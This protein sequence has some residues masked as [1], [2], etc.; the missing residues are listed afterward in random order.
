MTIAA[1]AYYSNNGGNQAIFSKAG[2][3]ECSINSS[4]EL[5]FF[6]TSGQAGT[7]L[8]LHCDGT[9][10]ST[11]FTD[12]GET[13]HTV[14]ANGNAQID[15]ALN[16]F[17]TGSGLFDGT[18]DYLSIPD[19]ND[20]DLETSNFTIDFW[21][22]FTN[23]GGSQTIFELGKYSANAGIQIQ[24]EGGTTLKVY[25]NGGSADLSVNWTPLIDTWYHVAIIRSG[26]NINA[27]INGVSLGSSA[28]SEDIQSSTFGA[29]IGNNETSNYFYGYLDEIRVVKGTAIWTE[30]FTPSDTPYQAS[31]S[32]SWKVSELIS[33]GWH[34][35]AVVFK[36]TG[37][38]ETDCKI[39][40]DGVIKTINFT[41]DPSFV[42]M[43]DTSSLFRI[44]T[45]SAAGA[46]NW[47]EK[48]DNLAFIHQELTAANIASLYTISAYQLT[49]VFLENE[50]FNV[51]FL[52][53][54][55]FVCQHRA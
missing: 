48:L 1:W 25:I 14:T 28:N 3:Y 30:D 23:T 29:R 18:G 10:G 32:N 40:V 27:Y 2:E 50:I 4:G 54:Q 15:T 47:K 12:S 26:G 44:G 5:L 24:T 35:V 8:L 11:T 37:A 7:K 53:K 55:L 9:D 17:G 45:T 38:A 19:S 49:T 16:K 39:Y 36:G 34:F 6:T 21:V 42:K 20:W 41:S 31:A 46:K 33:T 13:V 22:R 43:A 51:H 52:V